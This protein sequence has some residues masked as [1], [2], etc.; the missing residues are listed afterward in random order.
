[1]KRSYKLILGIGALIMAVFSVSSCTANFCS[2]VE[3][4]RMLYLIDPGVSMYT[5]QEGILDIQAEHD[6]WHVEKV[7]SGNDDL[8]RY[9]PIN[10]ETG[11]YATSSTMGTVIDTVKN[12]SGYIPSTEYYTTF[13]TFVLEYAMDAYNETLSGYEVL[14]T[15]VSSEEVNKILEGY[16]Y[17]KFYSSDDSN[18]LW[19][20]YDEING[21]V[22]KLIGDEK[23]ANSDYIRQYKITMDNSIS[24]LRS[25]IATYSGNY[26]SYGDLDKPIFIEAKDWGYAFSVG[27]IEGLLVFPVAWLVDSI[28]IAFGGVAADGLAQLGALVIVT[29]LVRLFLF[30]CTFKSTLSQQKMTAL[31]PELAKIQAKYPNAS[32][33]QSEKQRLSQEQMAFYKKNKINPLTQLLVVLIQFPLFIGV[34]GAMTGSSVLST[35]SLLGLKL[36]ASISNTLFD[37]S[38]LPSNA[39]GWWTALALIVLMSVAQFLAMKLPQWM[40]KSRSKKVARLSKNPTQDKQAN[41]MKWVSYGMLVMI[42]IMGFTLPA[43]MGIYWLIGALVSVLQTVITQSIIARGL[44]NKKKR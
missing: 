23:S 43:A 11:L 30:L 4:A 32:T 31:Q 12:E 5:D 44:K 16:G 14:P 38:Q 39:N 34:W 26:G 27:F 8:W 28:T 19:S 25:C 40:A 6:D 1:M 7:F 37:V 13:D 33:N 3:K 17:L 41:T 20:N 24:A 29:V 36:S 42:I 21:D 22:A 2:N 18:N 15:T 10:E 35:G 9:V